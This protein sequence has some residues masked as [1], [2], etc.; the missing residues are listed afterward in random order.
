MDKKR[1]DVEDFLF[2]HN[3]Y[4]DVFDFIFEDFFAVTFLPLIIFFFFS[5]LFIN[6]FFSCLGRGGFFAVFGFFFVVFFIGNGKFGF[7]YGAFFA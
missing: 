5:R 2:Y 1:A 4:F 6:V 3:F 7:F